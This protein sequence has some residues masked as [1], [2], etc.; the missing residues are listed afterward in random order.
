MFCLLKVRF[1]SK[2][3]AYL[4]T[5]VLGLIVSQMNLLDE[6]ALKRL[7][8]DHYA[9][10]CRFAKRYLESEQES[11]DVVQ[12]VFVSF[13]EDQKDQPEMNNVRSY[14]Y[15]AVSSRC[16]NL[17]K[18]EGMKQRRHD[19]GAAEAVNP[20]RLDAPDELAQEQELKKVVAQALMEMPDTTRQ[21]F[22]LSRY[23]GLSQKEIAE[24]L[25]CSVKNVEYHMG[26]ALSMLRIRLSDYG[27]LSAFILL[28]L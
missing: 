24:V 7:F 25:S 19:L 26:R 22:V 27:V 13:W 15:T 8:Y 21:A 28:H 3:R 20:S 2:P 10:L 11:E 17:L 1:C 4:Y 14:L 6:A 12:Q 18:R 16:L 5:L 9:E 23:H